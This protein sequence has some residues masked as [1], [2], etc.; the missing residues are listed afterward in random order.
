MK[1]GKYLYFSS[2]FA[3]KK[4]TFRIRRNS[5]DRI[6]T[7]VQ[8]ITE[9]HVVFISLQGTTLPKNIQIRF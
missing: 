2:N 8:F 4:Y 5:F 9:M 6:E 7:A 1:S 3:I